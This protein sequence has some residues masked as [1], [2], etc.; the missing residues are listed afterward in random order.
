MSRSALTFIAMQKGD[1][2]EDTEQAGHDSQVVS[3]PDEPEERLVHVPLGDGWCAVASSFALKSAADV[4]RVHASN[5]EL[6]ASRAWQ[7]IV[8]EQ[9][10]DMADG[11]TRAR[12]PDY[13]RASGLP[14]WRSLTWDAVL[15]FPR[16][17]LENDVIRQAFAEILE[18]GRP[19]QLVK[20]I[21]RWSRRSGESHGVDDETLG[22]LEDR[23][24]GTDLGGI[25]DDHG[26][27]TESLKRKLRRQ[28]ASK[29]SGTFD[30]AK[31]PPATLERVECPEHKS[32]DTIQFVE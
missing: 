21:K 15:R 5:P 28:N 6:R 19:S 2:S 31:L 23:A 7:R 18:N 22:Q 29:R 9:I 20:A 24:Y 11:I 10:V 13:G 4:A 26:I 17:A 14:S 16:Q 27:K 25:A 1:A 32:A 3:G 30:L 12:E 8:E